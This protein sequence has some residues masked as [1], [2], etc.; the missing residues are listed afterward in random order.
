MADVPLDQLGR[1]LT[2][3][4]AV[5]VVVDVGRSLAALHAE[6][7]GHGSAG[8]LTVGPE[9]RVRLAE[10]AA[11]GDPTVDVLDLGHAVEVRLGHDVPDLLRRLLATCRCPDPAGR[12]TAEELVGL[13][14]RIASPTPVRL[15]R[16]HQHRLELVAVV[17]VAALVLAVALGRAWGHGSPQPTALPRTM[18][19]APLD[20]ADPS[21]HVSSPA[22]RPVPT[23]WTALLIGHDHARQQ[24]WATGRAARLAAADAPRSPAENHDLL[25]LR[26]LHVRGVVARGWHMQIDRVTL[27]SRASLRATLR[28]RD[29]LAAYTLVA[30]DGTIRHRAVTRGP[31]WWLVELRKVDG[32][33]LT[34]SIQR[35]RAA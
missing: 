34:W 7:R 33:W 24:V 20:A 27:V 30:P 31:R 23:D 35:A 10:D 6:R 32:T 22:S 2:A 4:E 29:H 5:G 28:V 3:G 8:R 1:R 21:T 13:A 11:G 15:P 14:L 12:P 17:V 18:A 16:S 25:L 19:P 9:G 26:A